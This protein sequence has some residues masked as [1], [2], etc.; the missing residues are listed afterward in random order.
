[1]PPSSPPA[2]ITEDTVLAKVYANDD[3]L[4][5][6]LKT[7]PEFRKSGG[8]VKM[9]SGGVDRRT[10][11]LDAEWASPEDSEP[12]EDEGEDEEMLDFYGNDGDDEDEDEEDE[13]ESG[14]EED[15]EEPG[16]EEE[17]EVETPHPSS[18]RKRPAEPLKGLAA[19]PKKRVAF[20]L[21]K[22]VKSVNLPSKR[23]LPSL[24]VKKPTLASKRR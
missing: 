5:S 11:I 3:S 16:D 18:N 7:R 13:E 23:T 15:D 1:M 4:L 24:K 2:S 14:D 19:P 10:L 9:N 12:S 20:D 6:R 8:L 21:K 17:S 22:P